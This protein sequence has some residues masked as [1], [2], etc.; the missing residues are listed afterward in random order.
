MK[1]YI[2]LL[3]AFFCVTLS[4][5]SY[6]NDYQVNKS[7]LKDG[8]RIITI[9]SSQKLIGFVDNETGL[10]GFLN[11]SSRLTVRVEPI[12]EDVY[13]KGYLL[14]G[15]KKNGLW[16]I[17]DLGLRFKTLRDIREPIM[18]CKYKK[19]EIVD[20]YTV[21][22]DGRKWDMRDRYEMY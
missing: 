17:Y 11:N 20:N 21:I 5:S 4:T 13:D 3:V 7:I 10:V 2:A 1:K 8:V 12:F 22:C 15:V 9:P 6:V 16:G 14:I 18:E 19:V